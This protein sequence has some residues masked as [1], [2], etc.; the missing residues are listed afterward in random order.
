MH[1]LSTLIDQNPRL[2]SIRFIDQSVSTQDADLLIQSLERARE[3]DPQHVRELLLSY[4]SLSSD[5]RVKLLKLCHPN[6]SE[7]DQ[8]RIYEQ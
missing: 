7:L 1:T 5:Q 3:M 8:R 4:G 2:T 6:A